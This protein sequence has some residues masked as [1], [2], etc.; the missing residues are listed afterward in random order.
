MKGRKTNEKEIC[1]NPQKFHMEI[2]P[3][4]K[5]QLEVILLNVFQKIEKEGKCLSLNKLTRTRIKIVQNLTKVS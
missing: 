4:C 5:K 1:D 3:N 2:L